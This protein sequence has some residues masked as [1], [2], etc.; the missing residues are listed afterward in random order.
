MYSVIL[1]VLVYLC[2]PSFSN[3]A[4]V[5]YNKCPTQQTVKSVLKRAIKLILT[6]NNC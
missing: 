6:T 4:T 1:A 2:E 3:I 5:T